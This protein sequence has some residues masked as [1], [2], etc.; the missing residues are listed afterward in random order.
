VRDQHQRAP[1][2]DPATVAS[3]LYNACDSG[4]FFWVQKHFTGTM[5]IHRLADEGIDTTHIGRMSILINGGDNSYNERLQYAA[6]IERFR[7]DDASAAQIGSITATRQGITNGHWTSSTSITL[8]VNYT[9]QR[10]A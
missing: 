5:N 2:F 1:R 6:F 9:P 4:A 7:G 3:N 8:N 10:P